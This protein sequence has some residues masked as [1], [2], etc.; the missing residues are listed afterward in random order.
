MG[1]AQMYLKRYN[2]A[3]WAYREAY[4]LSDFANGPKYKLREAIKRAGLEPE[5]Q[6]YED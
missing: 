3:V 2:E 6:R 5:N 4:I 1:N